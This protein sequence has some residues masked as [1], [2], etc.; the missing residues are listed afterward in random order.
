MPEVITG[1]SLLLLFVAADVDP[2][3][4]DHRHRSHHADRLP[5]SRSWCSRASLS[6][7]TTLEEGG[8]WILAAPPLRT[9]LTVTLPLIAPGP[10]QR[11][12]WLAFTLFRSTIS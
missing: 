6:F 9:F 3:L 8:P 2:R 12:G 5:S 4:L 1:L 11:A 10:W 7:D